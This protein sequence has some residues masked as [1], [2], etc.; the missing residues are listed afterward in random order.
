MAARRARPGEARY[1]VDFSTVPL[2][3]AGM[4]GKELPEA[5]EV[6]RVLEADAMRSIAYGQGLE[7]VTVSLIYGRSWRTV[8]TPAQ[9][10]PTTGWRIIWQNEVVIPA[11]ERMLPHAPPLVGKLMR[12]ERDDAIQLVLFVFAHKGGT[13]IDYAEHCWAVATGPPGA[14]GL[15]IL[16]STPLI[17]DEVEA[18]KARLL[19]VAAGVYP[20][21][22]RFWYEGWEPPP[23]GDAEGRP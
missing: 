17:G 10:Y 6:A 16:L 22:V 20:H 3:V 1:E 2:Q 12:V 23:A 9:C 19:S 5:P 18:A 11:Q 8:H 15:S 7:R 4:Q 21:A 14:G 13:S